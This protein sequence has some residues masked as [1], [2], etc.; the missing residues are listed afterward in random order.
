MKNPRRTWPRPAVIDDT[1]R[2]T[3]T[4]RVPM[5]LLDKLLLV[6]VIALLLAVGTLT[7]FVYRQQLYIEGRGEYRDREAARMEAEN[8]ER[9]RRAACDLL[10]TFPEGLP[11]LERARAKYD[12]GPGIPRAL[13]TPEEQARISPP[14]PPPPAEPA[15]ASEFRGGAVLTPPQ[16]QPGPPPRPEGAPPRATPPEPTPEPPPAPAAPLIE[17]VC[18]ATGVCI[19]ITEE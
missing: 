10:D 8:A 3:T 16:T 7:F 13:L 19:T 15:P 14:P 1:E 4:V 5:R 2:A 18:D 9:T 11:A 17:T 12:C 6:A